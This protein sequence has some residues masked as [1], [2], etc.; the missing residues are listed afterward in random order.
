MRILL[1]TIISLSVA[2]VMGQ[3]VDYLDHNNT[4]ATL[5]DIG[6]FFSD[7]NQNG[8]GYEVP[9]G[10]GNHTMYHSR[11]YFMGVDA[12][13]AIHASLGGNDTDT[14]VFPGPYPGANSAQWS[15]RTW[16]IC[17]EEID[18]YKAYYEACIGDNSSPSD[19]MNAVVP[20]NALLTKIYEWPAHGDV[21]LGED[22]WMAPFFDN[23]QESNNSSGAYDPLNGDYPI[24]KGCCATWRV[25][26]DVVGT[27]T[28]SGTNPLG[29]ETRYQTFQYKN[30]GLLN[31]VTFVE[32]TV[33][34]RGTATYPEFVYGMYADTDLGEAFDDYIG[35]DST[36][37][38]Y[39]TYNGDNNDAD[40]GIDPPAFGI[41]GLEAPFSSVVQY[42]GNSTLAEVWNLMNGLNSAGQPIV[43]PQG[44][45][46]Q[47]EFGGNPNAQSGWSEIELQYP[48]GDRRAMLSTQHGVFAPGDV[49]TQTYALVYVQDGDHLQSVDALYAAADEV[50]AFYDT[51]ASAQCEGG[52]L[53]A[54]EIE[55]P[56]EVSIMPNPASDNVQIVADVQGNLNVELYDMS[57]KLIRSAE[58]SMFIE[59]DLS[60][61]QD[62]AY[63][64][65]VQ[66]DSGRTTK[67]LLVSH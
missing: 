28:F 11:F 1:T 49:I 15:N 66:H 8:P 47:F 13:G 63:I 45:M 50:H 57:G 55:A 21:T 30:F 54:T 65:F 51:I 27:H 31:N 67:K 43:D 29:I 23:W 46:T 40:Y 3:N 38:M 16:Q 44:N 64:V 41:V 10:S 9:K 59:L 36:R 5:P 7:P 12:N 60:N 35:S 53:S 17:Q 56:L 2:S 37:S 34:N 24:I 14:D 48:P 39:Y 25:D 19:C 20:S 58:G 18:L 62:G 42:N 4:N 26:N 33:Y 6:S 32:V 52:V 61:V 22:Y